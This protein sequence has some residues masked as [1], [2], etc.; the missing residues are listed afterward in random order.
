M[1]KIVLPDYSTRVKLLMQAVRKD[2]K[3]KLDSTESSEVLLR[4]F[5]KL[6]TIA[7]EEAK[8]EGPF[9]SKEENLK[10][11]R[12]TACTIALR[13]IL[14]YKIKSGDDTTHIVPKGA[15]SRKNSLEFFRNVKRAN[16]REVERMLDDDRFLI[17]QHN[18]CNQTPLAIAA[19]RN[20]I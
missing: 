5:Y 2:I 1:V 10:L 20:H 16:V 17:Y 4:N 14:Y 12:F 15:Y 9:V 13:K 6:Q 3:L 8:L 11:R 7:E 19:K 18:E